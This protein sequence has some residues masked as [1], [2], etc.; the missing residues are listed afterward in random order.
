M[1]IQ[2]E[3]L[4]KILIIVLIIILLTFVIVLL[5]KTGVMR[6]AVERIRNVMQGM[7]GEE[8]VQNAEYDIKQIE[9]EYLSVLITFE[10]PRG[11]EKITMW[12]GT[13]I[14]GKGKTKIGL[15]RI[16]EE[17]KEYQVM[18]KYK[19]E[20]TEELYT[21]VPT[22]EVA[23]IDGIGYKLEEP[24]LYEKIEIKYPENQNLKNYYRIGKTDEWKEYEG[25]FVVPLTISE[26]TGDTEEKEVFAKSEYKV[27]KTIGRSSK[28]ISDGNGLI[29]K[30][31]Y[32]VQ[33]EGNYDI[34]VNGTT[35][36]I[37][38]YVYN[39]NTTI[40]E[41][42]NFGEA[43]DSNT[44][45]V[46]VKVNGDL[47]IDSKVQISVQGTPKGMLI[48]C[49]GTLTNNGTITMSAKGSSATGQNV[50]LC[51]NSKVEYEYV[52]WC[53]AWGARGGT[54][55]QKEYYPYKKGADGDAATERKTGGGG[56][57]AAVG[58]SNDHG[59][60]GDTGSSYSGG[61]GGG[62]AY[63][64]WDTPNKVVGG[65]GHGTVYG[66]SGHT[67]SNWSSNSKDVAGSG[68]GSPGGLLIIYGKS[69]INN[70]SIT[71]QGT[72]SVKSMYTSGGGSGGGSINIF[73][74]KEYKKGSIS[75]TGGYAGTTTGTSSKSA[76]GGKGGNGCVTIGSMQTGV[77]VDTTNN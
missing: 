26:E 57:G 19:G 30:V 58:F 29:K 68:A 6:I 72:S 14:D 66:G 67:S 53:G 46:V 3:K 65:D 71:S 25:T 31:A 17:N 73:Y 1:K 74:K 77:F 27:G 36:L 18:V 61:A 62:A 55:I 69:V 50:Y 15:D 9:G 32:Q 39:E 12:D 11:I 34:K 5:N 28:Y 4:I 23:I 70:L 8:I 60:D 56:G 59:G 43:A 16:V 38:A 13:Q 7:E 24:N 76:R 35:Y 45:M 20:E 40:S 33:K 41:N 64:D 47:T 75:S 52:P 63:S 42:K 2:K 49:T 21:M 51:K 54:A 10:D 44:R 22:K 48:F 37:H